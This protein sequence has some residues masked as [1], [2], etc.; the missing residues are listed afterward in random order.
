M[1][2][3]FP[4]QGA[5]Q[6]DLW[7]NAATLRTVSPHFD[8]LLASPLVGVTL[9]DPAAELVS[10]SQKSETKKRARGDPVFE[11]SDEETDED[12]Y[13]KI[14]GNQQPRPTFPHHEIVVTTSS[15]TSY[16]A[17]LCWLQ[18]GYINFA[19]LASLRS[20]DDTM[21]APFILGQPALPSLASPKSIYRL[22]HLLDI[23]ALMR[24]ALNSIS[25]QLTPEIACGELFGDVSQ[26]YRPIQEMEL[27]YCVKHFDA[28]RETGDLD[29]YE[30]PSGVD[31]VHVAKMTLEL[32]K[33]LPRSGEPVAVSLTLHTSPRPTHRSFDSFMSLTL[34]LARCRPA[35]K[36]DARQSKLN[37]LCN[38]VVAAQVLHAGSYNCL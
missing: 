27:K 18:S 22:A 11:D 35:Q 3:V 15:F 30:V 1:H 26:A 16:R 9:E 29:D 23:P 5:G 20:E 10:A 38:G 28:I 7:A 8:R 32:L 19:P 12:Y 2:L 36:K 4:R 24:L 34:V 21:S 31:A 17:L 25:S 13:K 14:K 33:R 37:P 6:L